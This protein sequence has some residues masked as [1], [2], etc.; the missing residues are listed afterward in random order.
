[1]NSVHDKEGGGQTNPK[2]LWTS[3]KFRPFVDE[4]GRDGESHGRVG[5]EHARAPPVLCPDGPL[6]RLREGPLGARE[7]FREKFVI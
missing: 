5:G 4:G 1:M 2:F 3:Y 6:H 7:I